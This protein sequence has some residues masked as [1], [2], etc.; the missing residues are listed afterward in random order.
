MS[1]DG[2]TKDD[3][4]VPEG[5][6]GTKIQKMFTEEGKDISESTRRIP[7]LALLTCIRRHCSHCHGRGGCHRRQ[8]GSQGLDSLRWRRRL[9]AG[10]AE[11]GRTPV[12]S[13]AKQVRLLSH[14]TRDG[15]FSV[16]RA[17]PCA[18]PALIATNASGFFG[19]IGFLHCHL[20]ETFYDMSTFLDISLRQ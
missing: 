11:L 10:I 4:K 17:P 2:S 19:S 7:G 18:P 5:E 6:V 8:G 1:D 3:V 12:K 9:S 16:T 14:A 15:Y 20:R 13:L